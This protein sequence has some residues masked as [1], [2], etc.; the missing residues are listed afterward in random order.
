MRMPTVTVNP[1][2]GHH[3]HRLKQKLKQIIK[4]NI[5]KIYKYDLFLD[6]K[7]MKQ[8]YSKAKAK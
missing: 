3:M 2:H 4:I 5:C 8:R 1:K 6:S 7:C